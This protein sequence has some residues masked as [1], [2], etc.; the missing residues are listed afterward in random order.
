[1]LQW[2]SPAKPGVVS[3]SCLARK[4]FLES[5]RFGES[6]ELPVPPTRVRAT[7]RSSLGCDDH[8]LCAVLSC[9]GRR[10]ACP[11]R[12]TANRWHADVRPVQTS[13]SAILAQLKLQRTLPGCFHLAGSSRHPSKVSV[14]L[15]RRCQLERLTLRDASSREPLTRL[16]WS[17]GSKVAISA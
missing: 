11:V 16:R 17:C 7:L 4:Q 10:S 13:R 8:H 6:Q 12:A 5:A 14:I 1:L 9:R 3:W 2:A 15:H